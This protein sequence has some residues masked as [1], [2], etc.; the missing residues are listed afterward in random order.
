MIGVTTYQSRRAAEVIIGV[1]THLDQHVAVAIDGQGVRL[2]EN[3]VPATTCGYEELE[4]WSRSLGQ[5]RAFGI[6]GTGSYGAGVARFLTDRGHTV[7]EVNRPDR[8]VR[9]RKGK[10]WST[11]IIL[12]VPVAVNG[13]AIM[14]LS[15]KS[16]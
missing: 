9:Y 6:E 10:S 8:S 14:C 11:T 1:D 15:H 7:I 3:H 4:R 12:A 5:I 16:G 2:G 13:G